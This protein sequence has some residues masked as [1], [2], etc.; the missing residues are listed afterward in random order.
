MASHCR[1]TTISLSVLAYCLFLF[2]PLPTASQNFLTESSK[3][4]VGLYYESLCPYSANF[5]VNYLVDIFKD[6]GDL[7]S[8]IDLHL[9]PWGNARVRGNDT[10][11]CQHGPWECFLNTVEACAIYVWPKLEDHFPFI[12]CVEDLVYNRKYTEWETCFQKLNLDPEFITKCYKSEHGKELELRYA[13]ETN[14][15][16]P[17]HKYVPWVVVDGEPLYEDY[18]NFV[19][20]ICNAYKGTGPPKACNELSRYTIQRRN[21][22]VAGQV[23]YKEPIMSDITEMIRST[24]TWWMQRIVGFASF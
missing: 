1:S 14:S 18:E 5:I 8:A 2:S 19:T 10:F 6:N 9:S 7:L 24:M 16:Q 11:V 17:P 12:Y 15:L 23:C 13:A 21:A 4:S 3:V 20:Y 22:G